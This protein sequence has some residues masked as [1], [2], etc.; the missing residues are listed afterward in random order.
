MRFRTSIQSPDSTGSDAVH[1]MMTNLH[2]SMEL[3]EISSAEY[4]TI[5]NRL[6][7]EIQDQANRNS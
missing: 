1:S 7:S 6:M 3:G 2:R 4:R 5:K